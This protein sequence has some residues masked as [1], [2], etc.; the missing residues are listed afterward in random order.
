VLEYLH[1]QHDVE[2]P[3][4]RQLLMAARKVKAEDLEESS[5]DHLGDTLEVA[6]NGPAE[7]APPSTP[8]SVPMEPKPSP[9]VHEGQLLAA[10]SREPLPISGEPPRPGTMAT[11]VPEK[12]PSSGTVVLEVEQGGIVVPSFVGKSVRA[13]IEAAQEAGLELDAVGSGM[14]HDQNP[15]PGSH[16]AAGTHVLVHFER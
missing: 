2:L 15:V 8:A 10:A 14:G 3:A 12:M 11:S 9:D 16:V 13:A 4:S 6:D 7:P 1:T 5:P